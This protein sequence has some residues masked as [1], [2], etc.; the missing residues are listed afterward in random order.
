[1]KSEVEIGIDL[2]SDKSGDG[3]RVLEDLVCGG[4]MYERTVLFNFRAISRGELDRSENALRFVE[5]I[6]V[7]K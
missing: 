3:F 2:K 6:G 5:R 7:M 4:M 1:M